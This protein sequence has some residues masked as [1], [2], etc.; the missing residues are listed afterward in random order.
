MGGRP[1]SKSPKK[2]SNENLNGHSMRNKKIYV[3]TGPTACGKTAV[4]VALAK[5]LGGEVVS[6]DSMQIYKY[7][8]IGTAKP[9]VK[10]RGGVPH[11]LIDFVHPSEDYSVA[12]Y[13]K[14]ASD[15]IDGIFRRGKQPI[16]VGGSG[17][18]IDSLLSGRNFSARG[19]A[20]LRRELEDE[21]DNNGGEVMLLKLGGFDPKAADK[22]HA[23]DRKRIVR[24]LEAFITTGKTISEHDAETK[25]IPPR[26]NAAKYA[27]TFSDRDMLY[28]RIDNRVDK[29]ISL[30]L[31]DEVRTLLDMGISRKSTSMQAIGYK[32]IAAAIIEGTDFDIA[33]EKIKME[34]R[35]YAKRQLTWLRR[36]DSV[37]WIVWKS[38]PDMDCLASEALDGVEEY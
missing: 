7:M 5:R 9:T 15:C 20:A 37:K 24:A 21:Y 1:S 29:M 18:Y 33:I 32:E 6:A 38:E 17:L 12:R 2:K 8:D 11:H 4:A 22:L 34:S 27:L 26:Y 19:D 10:E 14:D 16:L 35:R 25:T 13:I 23:N 3:I 30:G 31:V 28:S 36:D